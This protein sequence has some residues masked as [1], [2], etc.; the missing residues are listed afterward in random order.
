MVNITSEML[1]VL[2]VASGIVRIVRPLPI[3]AMLTPAIAIR[4]ASN[5]LQAASDAHGRQEMDLDLERRKR[6]P[7]QGIQMKRAAPA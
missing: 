5:L 4:Y 1:P 6:P 7:I 3:G 2:A